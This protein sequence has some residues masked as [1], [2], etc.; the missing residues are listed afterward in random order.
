[1]RTAEYKNF[2]PMPFFGRMN[3]SIITVTRAHKKFAPKL[4]DILLNALL[5][6]NN[7]FRTA[8]RK[9]LSQ[10]AGR[11]RGNVAQWIR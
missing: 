3:A 7:P 6:V 4:S 8:A 5:W 11:T 2:I 10:A 9:Q 1:M